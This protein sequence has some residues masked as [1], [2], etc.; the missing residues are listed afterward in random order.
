[1]ERGENGVTLLPVQPHVGPVPSSGRGSV[2]TRLVPLMVTTVQGYNNYREIN[3]PYVQVSL[4]R[5][6][7]QMEDAGVVV[8]RNTIRRSLVN[9]GF[10]IFTI[11]CT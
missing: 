9:M 3:I 6:R 11:L 1:M 4:R 2:N 10:L 7:I 8:S 5:L